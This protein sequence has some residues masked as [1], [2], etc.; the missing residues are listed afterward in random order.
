MAS[1]R[2]EH[3]PFSG[4]RD[5]MEECGRLEASGT[6]VIHLEQGRPDFDTPKPIKD[7]AKTAIDEGKVHYTSNYGVMKLRKKISDKFAKDNGLRYDPG[8][9]IIVTSGATEA[10]FISILSMVDPG[11]EVLVPDPSW[12]YEPAIRAAMANP[13]YY[14][15]N[16]DSGYEPDINSIRESITSQTSVLI[17][18]TPQNPT[19]NVIDGEVLSTMGEIARRHDLIVISDEVY[20]KII[21]SGTHVSVASFDEL[22]ERTITINAV[23]KTFS[24]TGWRLG[25]LGAP[26]HLSDPLIR[27]RQFTSTSASSISQYAAIRAIGSDLYKPMVEEYNQRR[28]MLTDFFDG[29]SGITCP[30]LRGAFYAFPD[31]SS[32]MYDD[33]S[34][35]WDLL[36]ETGVALVPGRVFGNAG[37]GHVRIAYSNSQPRLAEAF[38][39]INDFVEAL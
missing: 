26:E 29:V 24:M 35:V 10:V 25:Y 33:E 23:S 38:E 5:I 3:I 18:N 34:F 11:D 32:L 37:K 1:K 30:E 8:N 31:I 4:I 19:G 20:E 12:T 17:I 7:A 36:Q 14:R 39:R 22:R 16:S 13:V 27:L 6:D 15:L 9:E 28:Q 2:M 21:F